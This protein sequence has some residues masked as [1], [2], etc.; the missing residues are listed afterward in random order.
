MFKPMLIYLRVFVFFHF[1]QAPKSVTPLQLLDDVSVTE[2]NSSDSDN[3]M[4]DVSAVEELEAVP[5]PSG[6]SSRPVPASDLSDREPDDIETKSDGHASSGSDATLPYCDNSDTNSNVSSR[7]VSRD[8]SPYPACPDLS[9]RR[10]SNTN[11]SSDV[12]QESSPCISPADFIPRRSARLDKGNSASRDT[13]PLIFDA[14]F[15]LRRGRRRG[16][17]LKNMPPYNAARDLTSF[18]D[19][20]SCSNSSAGGDNSLTGPG[21]SFWQEKLGTSRQSSCETG[22]ESNFCDI[23]KLFSN[24]KAADSVTSAA[25]SES[26]D[27][28]KEEKMD[29]GNESNSGKPDNDVIDKKLKSDFSDQGDG[30]DSVEDMDTSLS[31][32]NEKSQPDCSEN[33]VNSSKHKTDYENNDSLSTEVDSLNSVVLSG[34][35]S[36][37]TEKEA[38]HC[39]M[40]S[41]T[42]EDITKLMNP[43]CKLPRSISGNFVVSSSDK[44]DVDNEFT[45]SDNE[46]SDLTQNSVVKASI[47]KN[48]DEISEE[49]VNVK[50]DNKQ[51]GSGKSE[52]NIGD[53]CIPEDHMQKEKG[54][55]DDTSI[56]S[57]DNI[58]HIKSENCVEYDLN[59]NSKSEPEVKDVKELKTEHGMD[60]DLDEKLNIKSE[61]ITE[62]KEVTSKSSYLDNED[63]TEVK[64]DIEGVSADS[65][66]KVE[67]T[68]S[69]AIK[70][71]TM[72]MNVSVKSENGGKDKKVKSEDQKQ[73]E[74][75]SEDEEDD[76][77]E[78]VRISLCGIVFSSFPLSFVLNVEGF[79][80]SLNIS[81]V[82]CV[83]M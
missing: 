68:F 60:P 5:G 16:T 46:M 51:T 30:K 44:C 49:K 63:K 58:F 70:Q 18:F 8:S 10:D 59:E 15:G 41:N 39:E 37:P 29:I 1:I 79:R 43:D 38:D 28:N 65:T 81:L 48:I 3:N 64:K 61:S 54:V 23:S 47:K 72:K 22:D 24:S 73:E 17:A 36:A 25:D 42:E 21:T 32:N 2:T 56:K 34:R 55:T 14:D 26:I 74:T 33:M 4:D 83:E 77:E 82:L 11:R 13:S 71:E 52:R 53:Q 62:T 76:E 6:I 78:V 12:S 20:N 69:S 35:R 9:K 19:D 57:E 66:L 45:P 50:I 75:K 31:N 80:K 7:D 40:A 27:E 67:N